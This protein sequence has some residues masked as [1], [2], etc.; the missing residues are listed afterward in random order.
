MDKD[1]QGK[2]ALHH[3]INNTHCGCADLLCKENQ[4]IVNVPDNDGRTAAHD[5][6]IAGNDVILKLLLLHKC[7]I[8]F[9]D[10]G[11][12]TLAHWATGEDCFQRALNRNLL[13]THEYHP[14]PCGTIEPYIGKTP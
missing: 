7:D 10:G 3:T 14:F 9:K 5:A 4:K 11:G 6:V 13:F 12:H 8:N 1:N 2:T